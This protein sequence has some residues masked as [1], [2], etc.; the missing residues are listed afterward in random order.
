SLLCA[1]RS[2]GWNARAR[3]PPLVIALELEPEFLVADAEVAVGAAQ[4]RIGHHRLHLLRHHTDIRLV[5]AIV[6]KA[7]EA[8]AVVEHADQCDVVLEMDIG[9]PAAATAASASATTA[10]ETTATATTA[11]AT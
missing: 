4:D 2:S 5:A 11:E 7:I 3:G 10:A 9:A 8:K 1:V 6:G